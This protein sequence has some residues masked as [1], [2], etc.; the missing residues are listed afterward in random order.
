MGTP[1]VRLKPKGMT[2]VS[3]VMLGARGGEG[4][5]HWRR[6]GKGGEGGTRRRAGR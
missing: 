4:A 3:P 1:V 5:G 2:G 6:V